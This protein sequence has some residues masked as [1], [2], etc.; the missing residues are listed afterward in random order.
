MIVEKLIPVFQQCLGVLEQVFP[1]FGQPVWIYAL[2]IGFLFE[3]PGCVDNVLVVVDG[4]DRFAGI[5][6]EHADELLGIVA[7]LIGVA[8]EVNKAFVD[9]HAVQ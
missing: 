2:V 5:L 4:V 1:V 7:G 3:P 9:F 8:L 6:A